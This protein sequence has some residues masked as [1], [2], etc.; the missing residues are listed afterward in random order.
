LR[1]WL[2]AL[3]L[4]AFK[5]WR[6]MNISKISTQRVSH[7]VVA[8][9]IFAFGWWAY[10]LWTRNDAFRALQ[11][12]YLAQIEAFHAEKP[13]FDALDIEKMHAKN[14]RIIIAEGLFFTGCLFLGLWFINRS[15]KRQVSLARQRRNFMLSITHELK[16]PIASLRLVMETLLKRDL[17][18]AQTDQISTGGLRD[19][20]RLQTLV[21]DL[22]LAA[23]LEDKWQ[24]LPEPV[25]LREVAKEVSSA[26]SLRFPQANIALDIASDLAPFA[27]DKQG[28]ISVVQ[29]LLENALKYS[30]EGSPVRLC[31][32][33]KGT[34]L[35][36]QVEDQGQGIAEAEKKAIFAK[37]YRI[38]NEDTRKS[39]GTGLGL[40][41]VKQVVKAH[42]GKIT[43]LNNKPR[44]SIFRIELPL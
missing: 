42:N 15:T 43:V 21:E 28:I 6:R 7:I 1:Q 38:G 10:L 19:A 18:R 31:A 4:S 13:Q 39:T 2:P 27:F 34:I 11:I 5:P 41:I 44:G 17:N 8:Y 14:R 40:Y 22:L 26:L 12:Q 25:R 9:M 29:N 32:V 23:R 30:P 3:P 20:A 24:P 33:R 35:S 37:F 36:I 16:S